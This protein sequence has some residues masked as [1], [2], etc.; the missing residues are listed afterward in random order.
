MPL[1]CGFATACDKTHWH[2]CAQQSMSDAATLLE[3]GIAAG[4]DK[5][6]VKAWPKVVFHHRLTD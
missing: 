6:I 5:R 3:S 1:L 2:G 4:S